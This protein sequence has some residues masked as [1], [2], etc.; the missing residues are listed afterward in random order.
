MAVE[1]KKSVQVTVR[2]PKHVYER[3]QRLDGCLSQ[4]VIQ[5]ILAYLSLLD[6]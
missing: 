3:L 6:D 4:K 1:N 5:A 2:V